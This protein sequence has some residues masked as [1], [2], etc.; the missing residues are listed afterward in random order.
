MKILFEW[1]RL[2]RGRSRRLGV[3]RGMN[4]RH[5]NEQGGEKPK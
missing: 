5:Q 4:R 1:L 2:G 3:I